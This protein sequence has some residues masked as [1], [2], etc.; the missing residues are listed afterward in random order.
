MDQFYAKVETI[1]TTTYDTFTVR[2]LKE[3]KEGETL[4]VHEDYKLTVGAVYLFSCNPILFKEKEQLQVEEFTHIDDVEIS[5]ERRQ[6]LMRAFYEYSPV[7]STITRSIIESYLSKIENI[8][9]KDI[10]SDIY[11]RYQ[12]EF[13]LYPAATKFHHAYIGGLSYHT[14]TMMRLLDGFIEVYPF[15]NMDLLV[16]G[17]FLHDVCKTVELSN[18]AGPEY[19]KEGKLLGHI[20]MGVKL[21]EGV[22]L[23]LGYEKTEE[24]L[25]LEHMVLSH[26]YYGNYGSPKKTNIPEALVLHFVD[27][28]DSK[29]TVLEETLKQTEKG[30][31]TTPIGVLDREKYYKAIFHNKD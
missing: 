22:A 28:I 17:V 13:Y 21:I 23:K 29:M 20:T 9:I 25:L 24:V 10:T 26:H 3:N 7:D 4:R 5:F 8:V 16:A 19:T 14:S 18:Y 11:N 30:E 27:N 1:N 12:K 6:E 31:F 15:L 2:V